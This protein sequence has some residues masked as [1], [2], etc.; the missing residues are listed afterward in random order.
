[1]NTDSTPEFEHIVR[2][3][4]VSIQ[5][6]AIAAGVL[7]LRDQL[8]ALRATGKMAGHLLKV[9]GMDLAEVQVEPTGLA[10]PTN[11]ETVQ[12]TGAVV[13]AAEVSADDTQARGEE[14]QHNA[15]ILTGSE[16]S[17][18]T[19]KVEPE[20][21][22]AEVSYSAQ[23]MQHSAETEQIESSLGR[24]LL[25]LQSGAYE[26]TD[27]TRHRITTLI[28][29]LDR[30]S[31][32]THP[33]KLSDIS[34]TGIF[35][36][37]G[38]DPSAPIRGKWRHL[39][40]MLDRFGMSRFIV[41]VGQRGNA[42]Y[43]LDQEAVATA[44]NGSA[45]ENKPSRIEEIDGEA[46]IG[47][48]PELYVAIASTIYPE[49]AELPSLTSE[50]NATLPTESTEQ[51]DATTEQVVPP[52]TVEED[53]VDEEPVSQVVLAFQKA[54]GDE[55]LPD[56]F[57]PLTISGVGYT[58]DEDGKRTYYLVNKPQYMNG[59]AK[60]ILELLLQRQQGEI[61]FE[62]LRQKLAETSGRIIEINPINR[63]LEDLEK[64]LGRGGGFYSTVRKV[65]DVGYRYIGIRGI[66]TEEERGELQSFL[67]PRG[68]EPQVVSGLENEPAT[69]AV[70]HQPS[71]SSIY[72]LQSN[73]VRQPAS[74]SKRM[75]GTAKTSGESVSPAVK[76]KTRT[77]YERDQLVET[78]GEVGARLIEYMEANPGKQVRDAALRKLFPDDNIEVIREVL[79]ET[80]AAMAS[81]VEYR[82]RIVPRAPGKGYRRSL[83]AKEE[84]IEDVLGVVA[85]E[86]SRLIE[87]HPQGLPFGAVLQGVQRK[88]GVK[89]EFAVIR[90]ALDQLASHYGERFQRTLGDNLGTS[91]VRI[92]SPEDLVYTR[93]RRVR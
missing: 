34:A 36:E 49:P 76:K 60:E 56:K 16:N 78:Y 7:P 71:P 45:R 58:E 2:Q 19:S 38:Q 4:A 55:T 44:L 13:I 82:D 12:A 35:L 69:V 40:E 9:V 27:I 33:I 21:T 77:Q 11:L 61:D 87:K 8:V 89:F 1:M 10:S 29:V 67:A 81:S 86:M 20:T 70:S 75:S 59:L 42:R 74:T 14:T 57:I 31:S 53:A 43:Y 24:E 37:D 30:E 62:L 80:L 63:A 85:L 73:P 22:E 25:A 90:D 64:R 23:P 5:E 6:L 15:R 50:V 68:E 93:G 46:S 26:M 51:S 84:N 39:R 17:S 66:L 52:I 88:L 72:T 91:V 79:N 47:K 54:L 65:G 3:T 48:T 92:L 28:D 83:L 41:Q 32:R 18:T